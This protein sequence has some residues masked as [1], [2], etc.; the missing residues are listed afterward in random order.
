MR[1]YSAKDESSDGNDESESN[2]ID[3]AY[4]VEKTAFKMIAASSLG[5]TSRS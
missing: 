1:C 5:A 4:R 2:I 3:H